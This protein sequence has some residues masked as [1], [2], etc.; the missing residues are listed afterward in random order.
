MITSG[1]KKGNFEVIGCA[2]VGESGHMLHLTKIS[3]WWAMLK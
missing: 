1:A 2:G 3:Q